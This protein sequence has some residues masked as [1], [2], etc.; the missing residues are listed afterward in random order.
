MGTACKDALVNAVVLGPFLATSVPRSCKLVSRPP[1]AQE[2]D[3][4]TSILAQV[5]DVEMQR[6]AETCERRGLPKEPFR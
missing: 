3:L 6:A 4:A 5:A 1:F 2:F